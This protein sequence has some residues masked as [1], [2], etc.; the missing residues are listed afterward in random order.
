MVFKGNYNKENR[1]P[2]G[3]CK[4]LKRDVHLPGPG[5]AQRG[6]AGAAGDLPGG[7]GGDLWVSLR[8]L[9]WGWF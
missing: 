5:A 8:V 1:T 9:F 7:F 2:F 3:G 6:G 4:S